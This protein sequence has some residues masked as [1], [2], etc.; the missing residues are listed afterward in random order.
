MQWQFSEK[1]ELVH[2]FQF[3]VAI[4]ARLSL[5]PLIPTPADTVRQA[6]ESENMKDRLRS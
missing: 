2:I 3:C 6:R 1:S 4:D 5:G